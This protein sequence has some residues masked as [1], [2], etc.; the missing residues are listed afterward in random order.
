MLSLSLFPLVAHAKVFDKVAVKINTEIV[1]L[2]SV[3]ER[4]DLLRQKYART[5][6]GIPEEELLKEALNMII[7]ERLM[8]QEGKKL[9]F[10]AEEGNRYGILLDDSKLEYM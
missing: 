5:T 2:S 3:K 7:E 4:A 6:V 8:L 9:G 1:T 10:I